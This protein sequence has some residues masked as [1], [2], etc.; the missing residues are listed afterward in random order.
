MHHEPFL[1][2]LVRAHER[3]L[4]SAA[5]QHR[6]VRSVRPD[7]PGL[8]GHLRVATLAWLARGARRTPP[9]T[10]RGTRRTAPETTRESAPAARPSRPPCRRRDATHPAE[11]CC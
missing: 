4:R 3:D 10:T 5:D 2:D 8:L 7:R 1:Y 6:L 11:S 9:A